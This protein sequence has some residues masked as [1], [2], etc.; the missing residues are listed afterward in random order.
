MP[1]L[2]GAPARGARR[3]ARRVTE[4]TQ[5]AL[6]ERLVEGELLHHRG[7]GA[8]ELGPHAR[9]HRALV[10]DQPWPLHRRRSRRIGRSCHA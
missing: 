2:D 8:L 5:P 6:S 3:P 1:L 9:R 7:D 4:A 10:V